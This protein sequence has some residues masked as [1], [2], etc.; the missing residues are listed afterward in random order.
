MVLLMGLK[1]HGPATVD[2]PPDVE[3]HGLSDVNWVDNVV[4]AKVN[5]EAGEAEAKGEV[6]AQDDAYILVESDYKQKADDI[7]AETCVDPTKIWDSLNVPNRSHEECASGFDLE[8]VSDELNS[9]EGS[10][11]EK[12][13]KYVDQWRANP[14]WNYTGMSAQLRINTN[15]DASKWQFYRARKTARQMIDGG[16]K[17]QYSKLRE[18]AAEV[19]RMNPDTTIILKC[20]GSGRLLTTIGVNPNNQM[21][22]VAYALVE[23]ETKDT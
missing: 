23:A 10:D 16:V 12:A 17:D 2:G 18:Y 6:E 11:G 22:P 19:M 7:T 8:D 21:Y 9:L 5:K 4:H 14:D 13:E 20:D 1:K 3:L 15:M